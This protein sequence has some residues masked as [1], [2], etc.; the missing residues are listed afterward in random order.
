MY[1][2]GDYNFIYTANNQTR[3]MLSE[4][5]QFELIYGFGKKE[6]SVKKGKWISN[7][8]HISLIYNENKDTIKLKRYNKNYLYLKKNVRRCENSKPI[9]HLLLLKKG[10]KNPL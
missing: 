3:L 2:S 8:Q 1:A 7:K 6:S 10:I 4:D 5:K 9:A